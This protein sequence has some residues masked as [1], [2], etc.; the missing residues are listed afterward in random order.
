MCV[1]ICYTYIYIVHSIFL[2]NAPPPSP[3]LPSFPLTLF[4]LFY[5]LQFIYGISVDMRMMHKENDQ[6]KIMDMGALYNARL[7]L[8]D[9]NK[10]LYCDV[11]YASD[12]LLVCRT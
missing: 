5:W 4:A 11:F 8:V 1:Y 2:S 7:L 9:T 6:K 10:V 12:R 3:P